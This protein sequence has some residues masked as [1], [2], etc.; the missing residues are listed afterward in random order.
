MVRTEEMR[1]AQGQK[2]T[3]TTDLSEYKSIDAIMMPHTST[4]TIGPQVITYAASEIKINDGVSKKD[5]K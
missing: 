4:L 5:F 2:M 3:Q 1:E